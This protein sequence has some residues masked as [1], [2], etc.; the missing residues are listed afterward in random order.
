MK[1]VFLA[2]AL[3]VCSSAVLGRPREADCSPLHLRARD[4]AGIAAAARKLV[5]PALD[6]TTQYVCRHRH[7]FFVASFDTVRI[8]QPDGSE[9]WRSLSCSSDY[10]RRRPWECNVWG[11]FRGVP[12]ASPKDN[13]PLMVT[14]PL[15]M[16]VARARQDFLLALTLL[17]EP[18]ETD[19]CPYS[20]GMR[21]LPVLRSDPEPGSGAFKE[22]AFLRDTLLAAKGNLILDLDADGFALSNFPLNVHFVFPAG[23][24]SAP[25][26]R[27]W[28]ETE[29]VVTS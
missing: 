20:E 24:D 11:D 17:D 6:L 16:D 26:V 25:R 19:S 9:R 5:E 13:V 14:I 15:E 7:D 18:G 2:F 12:V 22:F 29:V 3:L 27:C 8:S 21:T 23:P 4:L 28:S 1:R 10:R